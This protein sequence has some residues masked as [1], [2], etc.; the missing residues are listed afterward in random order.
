MSKLIGTKGCSTPMVKA[1]KTGK[2]GKADKKYII[3]RN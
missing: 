3:Y 2:V 1:G